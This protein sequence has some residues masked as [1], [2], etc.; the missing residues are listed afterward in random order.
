[1]NIFKQF[2][3]SL[4]SPKMIAS[5]RHHKIG[6]AIGYV[7]LLMFITLIPLAI[8]LGTT[9]YS[10]VNQLENH[11]EE[12]VPD[13]QIQNGL[14]T[15]DETDE[16]VINEEDGQTIIFDPSGEL[17][18][19]DI[20][21]NYDEAIALLER[22]AILITNGV[23]QQPV[24][25]QDLDLNLTK[26]QAVD[27]VEAFSGML[28]LIISLIIVLM[29][30][31]YTASKFIGVTFLALIGFIFKKSVGLPN[32][33]Y[34]HSWVLAA[35]TVTLPTTIFALVNVTGLNIPFQFGIYWTIAIVML[36]QVLRYIPKPKTEE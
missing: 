21:G 19:S 3:A 15:S 6:R 18:Q 14:L 26:T 20:S 17:T 33:T 25:Y 24:S 2:I 27:M 1:M 22:E 7:F 29:Y 9:I 13:F 23:T 36:F 31:F 10:F 32:M 11:L 5:F 28:P 30:L 16:P 8:S 35:F 34:K 4:Y 12:N